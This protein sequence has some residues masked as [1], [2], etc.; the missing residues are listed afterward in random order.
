MLPMQKPPRHSRKEGGVHKR[1]RHAHHARG[2]RNVSSNI[3]SITGALSVNSKGVGYISPDPKSTREENIEVQPERLGL[4]LHKDTV[5]VSILKEKKFGRIQGE[6]RSI[7]S[8]AR[9]KFVGT[10]TEIDGRVLIKPDDYRIGVNFVPDKKIELGVKAYIELGEWRSRSESPHGKVLKI[11]GKKGVNDVEMESIVLEKGFDATFDEN[12]SLDAERIR[13]SA[14]ERITKDIPNRKD[15]RETTTFTIDPVDAKDFD[16]ALSFKQLPNGNYEIGIHIADVSFFL[17]PKTLLDKEAQERGVSIYLVDRTIP[18]LPEALSN[19]LCSLNPNEDKLAFSAVFEIT[20]QAKVKSRWFGRTIINSNKRFTYEGAQDV[21]DGKNTEYKDELTTLNDL[22]KI[23]LAERFKNGAISF[24]TDEV[25]FEIDKDGYPLR[26]FRK[27]RKDAHKLIEEFMLLANREVA[28]Y[29]N[30]L[31]K[32]KNETPLF[33]Y[34]IHDLPNPEKITSL[35]IFL[36]AVGY[37]LSMQKGKITAK[38]MNAL[39]RQIEG[40]AEEGIIKTA[41]IRSMAKAIYSTNN[42][43]HFGLGFDYY[44]HFTSPIRRYA[45]VLVHRLLNEYLQGK[46]VSK[47]EFGFYERMSAQVTEREIQAAEAERESVKLKQVEYMSERI[48]KTFDGTI[49]GVTE[50]GLYIED[51]ETKS[52]GLVKVRDLGDDYYN[53]DERNYCLVGEKTHKKYS[54]GDAVRFKVIAADPERKT[55]D[56]KLI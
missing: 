54:L 56:Y 20:P 9:T 4:A 42:I 32:A 16:D 48:G 22:A 17:E 53:L 49:S 2:M 47:Q 29:V 24:E 46:T 30:Q 34:R 14:K 43:G 18:M 1:N 55:L 21:L 15:F 28:T 8:R 44:T 50:W 36:K 23:L 51:K 3:K 6:V 26:V 5:E 35:G 13:Q 37:E 33:V 40:E 11:L 19:D 41:A 27:V 12:V 7:V 38:D 10:A 45:D 31:H 39:F 52:E 25:K